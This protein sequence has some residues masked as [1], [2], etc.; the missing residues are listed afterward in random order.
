MDLLKFQ[1]K[2]SI[3]SQ[4]FILDVFRVLKAVLNAPY[5]FYQVKPKIRKLKM[6]QSGGAW[7]KET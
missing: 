2:D 6:G 1:Q 3:V 5:E 7:Y 4:Y